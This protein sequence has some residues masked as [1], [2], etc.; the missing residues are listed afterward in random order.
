MNRNRSTGLLHALVLAAC[1][2]AAIASGHARHE[3]SDGPVIKFD[4]TVSA[5]TVSPLLL[6]AN[7]RWV[8]DAAGS[9]DPKTGLTY[10]R[11]LAQIKDVGITMIRY[12]AGLLVNLF[13]WERA[14]GPQAERGLQISGLV[15][16]PVPFDSTFG[17]DEFGDLLDKTG[18]TGNLLINFATATA[19]DAANFMLRW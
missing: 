8:A 16:A 18:A 10:P 5:G 15:I 2:T 6:G 12:P 14:I 19:A 9:A 1:V 4:A 17:P 3:T 7:H 13:Q 11:V